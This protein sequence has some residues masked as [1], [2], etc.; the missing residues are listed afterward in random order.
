MGMPAWE[1]TRWMPSYWPRRIEGGAPQENDK[2]S[3][4]IHKPVEEVIGS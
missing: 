3:Q 2:T 1:W 4:D